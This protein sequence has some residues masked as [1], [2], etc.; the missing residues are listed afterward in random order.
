MSK[1]VLKKVFSMNNK[2]HVLFAKLVTSEP[3]RK[4]VNF[5]TLNRSADNGADVAVT[6][7]FFL[8]QAIS[9]RFANSVYGFFK[10]KG[11][12]YHVVKIYVKNTWSKYGLVKLMMNSTNKL[13][14]FKFNSKDR[15]DVMLKYGPWF[16]HNIPLILKKWTLD[17]NLLKDDVGN[18]PVW[19]KFHNV[20]ITA[21]SKDGLS[22]IETKLGTLLMIDS[23]TSA[24]CTE[25][26]GRSSFVRP[27]IELRADVELKDTIMVD[28]Q[29]LVGEGFSKCTIRVKYEWKPHG[30]SPC[31]VYNHVLDDC[32]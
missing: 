26:R 2:G 12:A 10:G 28:V 5:R 27:M 6:L 32:P 20:P 17:W 18:V 1:Q 22:A 15:M 31:K 24:M 23:F 4:T 25:S 11:I 30:C 29:K 13:F 7:E 8:L 19:V 9:D 16:I 14:F 21:F 3:S